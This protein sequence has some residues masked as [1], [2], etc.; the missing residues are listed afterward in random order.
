MQLRIVA[1]LAALC[2]G[3]CGNHDPSPATPSDD[4][5]SAACEQAVPT[6]HM[7]G[8]GPTTVQQVRERRGGPGNT[9]PASTPWRDLPGDQFATWCTVRVS[10]HFEVGSATEGAPFVTFMES[11][12]NLGVYPWGPSLP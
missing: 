2:V 11:E 1:V 8:A 5:A 4:A 10:R 9:S 3:G 7:L 12:T 6:G